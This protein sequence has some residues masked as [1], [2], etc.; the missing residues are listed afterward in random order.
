MPEFFTLAAPEDARRTLLEH[1]Q[2]IPDIEDVPTADGLGRVLA[3][4]ITSPQILPEF[5]RSTV[6]GYAVRAQ[7]TFGAGEALPAYLKLVGEVPM[8][9]AAD[10]AVEPGQLA[11]VHTGGMIPDGADA[12]VMIEYT[13]L[14]GEAEV[15]VRRPAAPGENVIQ[16][17]E[18]ITPGD[19][20]LPAGSILRPQDIGGL[21]AVGIAH[22]PARRRPRVAIFATGDEVI[23]P[24][25]PTQP[26]QVR[27]VN[28]YTVSALVARAGGV[29]MRGSILPDQFDVLLE[30]ARKALADGADM[31]VLSAGSSVSVRDMTSDVFNQLG[32][33]GVLVHGIATKPGKPT[34]LGAAGNIPVIGLPGNPVSAFVQFMMVGLP[35]LYRLMGA[36]PPRSIRV[37]ANLTAN[38]ASTAGREDYVPC[39]LAEQDGALLAEPIF[40]KSNL[41]FT[42]VKADGLIVVPL[43]KTGLEAGDSVEIRLF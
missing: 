24:H 32:Q 15:E 8:G 40:F 16:P 6:D 1:I 4:D 41:I 17:G 26:G 38:V 25:L 13:Q 19:L 9:R 12:V 35:V 42:L 5:R 18:D 2:P 30:T 43:D 7:D 22:I 31:L 34:I 33:P 36:T 27:D 28:A 23:E 29:P 10:L 21:L 14:T 11:L 37:R 39:K 20:I 3:R